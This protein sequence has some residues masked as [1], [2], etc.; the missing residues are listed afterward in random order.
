VDVVARQ[1]AMT[2]APISQVEGALGDALDR[3]IGLLDVL[4]L[5]AVVI[6][7]LG[8]VN[9]LSMDTWERVRELAMLRAAGM[10]RRQVWRS[11]LVE[12]GILGAIGAVVGSITGLGIGALLIVTDGS[13]QHGVISVPWASIGLVLVLGVVLSMVAAAQPARIAGSRGI[14]SSVRAE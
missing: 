14:I 11:V 7:A 10:S 1:L 2:T 6:A 5:A 8:I 3:V 4:A 12:A 13:S 9:T